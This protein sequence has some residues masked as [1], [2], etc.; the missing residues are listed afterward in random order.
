MSSSPDESSILRFIELS[1]ETLRGEFPAAYL[2]LCSQLAPR[3]VRMMID[4]EEISLAFDP[5]G[6]HLRRDAPH[7]TIEL[8]T[9][10]QTIL[11]VLD[12]HLT[13]HEAILADAILLRGDLE[14]LA[15]LHEGLLTYVRGAV[16]CP[17]FPPLLDRFRYAPAGLLSRDDKADAGQ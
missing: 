16:R 14:D 10:R 8:Q 5:R 1:L 13:L 12:A 9:A 3:T 15:A 6:A 11:S 17:S 4:G 2:L 7:P